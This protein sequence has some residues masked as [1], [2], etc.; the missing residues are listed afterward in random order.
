MSNGERK[1]D[2]GMKYFKFSLETR[3]I[4]LYYRGMKKQ[5]MPKFSFLSI[6]YIQAHCEEFSQYMN[7]TKSE[8]GK[9]ALRIKSERWSDALFKGSQHGQHSCNISMA[10]NQFMLSEVM[11]IYIAISANAHLT[12]LEYA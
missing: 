6:S 9:L 3:W 7:Q 8:S 12:K 5:E 10:T 2:S 11:N 1:M 4:F